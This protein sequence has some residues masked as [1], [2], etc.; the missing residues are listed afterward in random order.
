M[1]DTAA[2]LRAMASGTEFSD[3]VNVTVYDPSGVQYAQFT[4]I[5]NWTLTPLVA[6]QVQM[7]LSTNVAD[8]TGPWVTS[9]TTGNTYISLKFQTGDVAWNPAGGTVIYT[10][11]GPD[12][13]YLTPV[14]FGPVYGVDFSTQPPGILAPTVAGTYKFTPYLD[15]DLSGT[16]SPGDIPGTPVTLIVP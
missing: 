15:E 7:W 10:V 1:D 2:T 5:K 12:A 4:Q 16:V 3:I 6:T 13:T 11:T 14:V 9:L 8:N